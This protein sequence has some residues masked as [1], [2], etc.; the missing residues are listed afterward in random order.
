MS[1]VGLDLGQAQDHTAIVVLERSEWVRRERDPVTYD[2]ERETRLSIRHLER[3]PLRTPYPDVVSMARRVVRDLPEGR[4][5]LVMDATGVGGPVV[6]LLKRADL[7]CPVI[8]VLITGGD[9]ESEERGVWRVP[10]RDLLVGLQVAF[11]KRWIG[12]ADCGEATQA[13]V[14]ELLGT[15]V[16]VSAD[17]HVRWGAARGHDDLVMAAALAWWRVR[18][19][20]RG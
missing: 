5:E 19:V 1:I 2:F 3:V 6:D 8:P 9:G 10:K 15:R 12:V 16:R 7:Q 20:W 18:R 17:G 11:E 4:R 13:F 14:K